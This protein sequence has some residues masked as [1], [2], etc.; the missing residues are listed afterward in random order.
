MATNNP[1]SQNDYVLDTCVL[2]WWLSGDPR[3]S[4]DWE[5]R[6]GNACCV[7]SAVSVWEVAIKHQLG[8]LSVTARQLITTAADAGFAFMAIS[9]DHAAA[10]AELPPL[11]KDPFDR[12]MIAQA[13]WEGLRFLTADRSLSAYGL[14]IDV[15]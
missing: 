1:S 4:R 5:D 2:L 11:H 9:P 3:L 14:G 10:T 8:K 12:L 6:L 15:L 7:V 13:R